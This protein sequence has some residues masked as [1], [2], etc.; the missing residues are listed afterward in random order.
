MHTFFFLLL[1]V[2]FSLHAD[3]KDSYSLA[4][5]EGEPAALIGG[6]VSAIT[7]DLYLNEVDVIVQ[8]YVPLRLPRQYLSGDGMSALAGWSFIDHLNAV[9]KG[10]DSEHKIK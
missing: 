4:V 7:G 9:Y 3:P 10:G 5:K 2:V 1:L 8:G 6:C